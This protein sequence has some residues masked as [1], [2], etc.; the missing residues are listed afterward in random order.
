MPATDHLVN[1]QVLLVDD[2]KITQ[3][4]LST[5]FD[6]H[7]IHLII[8]EN[9]KEAVEILHENTDVALIFMDIML[10][11]WN[12]I[13]TLTKIKEKIGLCAPV[14]GV[15]SSLDEEVRQKAIDAG[16]HD[17]L[18]KPIQKISLFQKVRQYSS[19]TV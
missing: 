3:W 5:L 1:Q 15:T 6:N 9:G 13:H 11:D 14:I 2:D 10:P 12:G 7:N 19:I 17:V 18:L 4:V 8:A 16:M